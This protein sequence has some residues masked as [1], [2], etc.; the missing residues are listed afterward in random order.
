MSYRIFYHHGFELGLATKVA[1]GVLDIDD[2][3]IAIKSGGNAYHIAF[4]DVED[5]EL[6]RLHKVGRVIRLTHSGGTHFV[7]VVRFMVGQF[8]LINFLATGRVFN[9]IQSAVNSK[10]NQA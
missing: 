8:A 5:V 6:I 1:K 4:H 3:A 9:R 7:S 10:H 2:K